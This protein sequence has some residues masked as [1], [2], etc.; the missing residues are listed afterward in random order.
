MA[1]KKF[2]RDWPNDA[3]YI[4]LNPCL[5]TIKGLLKLLCNRLGVAEKTNDDMWL[6]LA[7]KLRDGMV[8]IVDEA[9]HLPIKTLEALRALTDD[10]AERGQ[11]LGLALVGNAETVNHFG[12]RKKAEFAQISNRTRQKKVYT[13]SHITRGDMQLL[14]P[15]L[16]DG[17]EVDFLLAVSRS[18]QA[19]RGAVNLYSNAL[20]NGNTS[21]EGL[22][23]MAKSMD[24]SA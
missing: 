13:T 10:F 20:D 12:G 18:L 4:A 11:T 7:G 19:I 2:A 14:F 9:Q 23:A 1:A 8:L 16:P 3:L 17:A 6:G 21:Y 22:V 24:I 15:D 5:T